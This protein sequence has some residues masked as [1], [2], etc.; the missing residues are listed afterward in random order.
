MS[1]SPISDS[2]C[3]DY[4]IS[5]SLPPPPPSEVKGLPFELN[6]GAQSLEGMSTILRIPSPIHNP[7]HRLT[8]E[9]SALEIASSESIPTTDKAEA[10]GTQ[11]DDIQRADISRAIDRI[12]AELLCEIFTLTFPYMRSVGKYLIEQ[13]PWRLG[14]VCQTWRVAALANPLFWSSI[15]LYAPPAGWMG[16]ACPPLM[17][18]TQL[19]RS[20]GA[21]LQVNFDSRHGDIIDCCSPASIDLILAQSFR[22]DTASLRFHRVLAHRLANRLRRVKANIP[23]LRSLELISTHN[24]DSIIGDTFSI[25]PS[26]RGVVLTD[27]EYGFIS[28]KIQFPWCQLTK[29]RGSYHRLSYDC[30]TILRAAPNLVECGISLSQTSSSAG[31]PIILG[32]LLRL[33]AI[34]DVLSSLVAPALEELWIYGSATASFLGFLGRS[35]CRLRKLVVYDCSDP[36]TLI[37]ILQTIPTLKTFFVD[38]ER[39]SDNTGQTALFDAL[40]LRGG[41]SDMC[42]NLTRIAAGGPPRF[43]IDAFID[44]V[45]SR[46]YTADLPI[47]SFVRAF[48]HYEMSRRVSANAKARIDR[49]RRKELDVAL[50]LLF[51]RSRYNYL[52]IDRP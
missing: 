50:D 10:S 32:N 38:F 16:Q 47:L 22:W 9:I 28:P 7:M 43:A 45:E 48:S 41:A 17:I 25:A 36:E 15:T 19:I 20:G 13:A 29:F 33:S 40:K 2:D 3:C 49:M 4:Q 44:M 46:W 14:H 1:K 39:N 5:C 51:E 35:S 34:G 37:P 52:G 24:L 12:P 26:L 27:D 6:G 23:A 11:N 31:P 21:P 18:E 30:A 42:P 8:T